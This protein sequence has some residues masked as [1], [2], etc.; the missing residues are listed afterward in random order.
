[1]KRGADPTPLA[2]LD[3]DELVW[4]FGILK[5]ACRERLEKNL[6]SQAIE[7]ELYRRH[8]QL[9]GRVD[10]RPSLKEWEPRYRKFL[11]VATEI[12]GGL[13]SARFEDM[14]GALAGR[15]PKKARRR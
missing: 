11:K 7:E 15:L 12:H 1:M 9:P 5:D 6:I 3:R 13:E 14:A 4:F 2:R 8:G 10:P